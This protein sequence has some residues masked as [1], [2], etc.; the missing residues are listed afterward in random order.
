MPSDKRRA[1]AKSLTVFAPQLNAAVSYA[2][3]KIGFFL[4]ENRTVLLAFALA[5]KV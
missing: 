5:D 1:M 3:S 4:N 2:A